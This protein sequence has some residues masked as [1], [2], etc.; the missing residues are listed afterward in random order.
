Y[1]ALTAD[2]V[3]REAWPLERALALLVDETGSAFDA[4]CVAALKAVVE[5]DEVRWRADLERAADIAAR[6]RQQ[7]KRTS[8]G[9]ARLTGTP[10]PLQGQGAGRLPKANVDGPGPFR[11][12]LFAVDDDVDAA[13]PGGEEA[14]DGLGVG[15]GGVLVDPEGVGRARGGEV[16]RVALVGAVR[17]G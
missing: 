1:D 8:T 10:A 3:Y 5:P 4:D 13:G 16:G 6:P 2:R 14:F 17:G 15:L 12:D 9:Q 11:C 7:I